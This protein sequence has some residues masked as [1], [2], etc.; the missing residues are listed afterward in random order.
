MKYFSII[1]LVFFLLMSIFPSDIEVKLV[2]SIGESENNNFF[3]VSGITVSKDKSIYVV[4]SRENSIS[5]YNWMGEFIKK[6]GQ[7]GQGP[8]DFN[9]P[10]GIDYYKKNIYVFD[11]R[12]HR[13]V[14]LD[15]NLVLKKILNL[16]SLFNFKVIDKG[17]F[18]GN[19]ISS[20]EK[21]NAGLIKVINEDNKI[22]K[23][24]FNEIKFPE[25]PKKKSA[26]S[27][28]K[29]IKLASLV[30][31]INKEK[32]K[33]LVTKMFPNNPADFYIYS[34]EGAFLNKFQYHLDKRY[35]SPMYKTQNSNS[36]NGQSYYYRINFIFIHRNYILV[37]INSRISKDDD[38]K[39]ERILIIFNKSGKFIGKKVIPRKFGSQFF[40]LTDDTHL[41]GVA[42]E[43]E[44]YKL[45]ILKI[46]I[47]N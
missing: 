29:I 8:G 27:F 28:S 25:N 15:E 16:K 18:L 9:S 46:E 36:K 34:T 3:M 2:R 21:N 6:I 32:N 45:T 33:I 41:L 4:N 7:K 1:M 22:V 31:G 11:S 44:E 23:T 13:V 24:F 14:I 30:I 12:N 38:E 47:P 35:K 39:R 42:L 43:D 10:H 40:Y 26:K 37:C 5:K 19:I 20:G 17:L